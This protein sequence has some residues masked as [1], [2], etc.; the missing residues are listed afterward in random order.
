MPSLSSQTPSRVQRCAGR[1]APRAR[2]CRRRTLP[3]ARSGGR[4]APIGLHGAA[5]LVGAGFKAKR[6]AR[7]IVH[8]GQRM[9]AAAVGERDPALEVHL[10]EQVRASA[11]RTGWSR[12][13][14]RPAAERY[15]HGG[16]GSHARSRARA[17]PIPSRARQRAILRAPQAGCASRTAS[18]RSSIAVSV[19]AGL[20]MRTTRA[21]RKLPVGT[22]S[23]QATCTPVSGGSRTAGTAPAGS[24]PPASQARTNSRR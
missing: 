6:V 10:P 7:M 1:V 24:L 3:A 14:R 9:A 18:M 21:I 17:A 13:R 23:G 4:S 11:S 5:L 2:R 15:D 12:R 16:A 20:R 22:P 8:H 19:R